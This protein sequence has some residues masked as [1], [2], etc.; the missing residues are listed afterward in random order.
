MTETQTAS[1]PCSRRRRVIAWSISAVLLACAIPDL[2]AKLDGLRLVQLSDLHHT[3]VLGDRAGR[4]SLG[5]ANATHAYLSAGHT[6]GRV[7]IYLNRGIGTV[8]N[9]V[10]SWSTTRIALFS[11]VRTR[12]SRPY[13]MRL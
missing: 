1:K 9:R 3:L 11:L 2:P 12:Q 10:H 8:Y 4:E 13:V 7:S 5:V 6:K